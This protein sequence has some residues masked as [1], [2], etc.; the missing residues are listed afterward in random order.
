V[1]YRSV[2]T[3]RRYT[4]PC[5]FAVE[6]V[7]MIYRHWPV[8]CHKIRAVH[9]YFEHRDARKKLLAK[10]TQ[11]FARESREAKRLTACV[12]VCVCLLPILSSDLTK[13]DHVRSSCQV[14]FLPPNGTRSNEA[15][16]PASRPACHF[17]PVQQSILQH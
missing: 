7:C 1:N 14:P 16:W 12:C 5:V 13:Q 9:S 3:S 6:L 4:P 8:T 2:V 17:T 15:V 11:I 10:Q